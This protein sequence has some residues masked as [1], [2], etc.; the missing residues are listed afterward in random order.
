MPVF[1]GTSASPGYAD[2]RAVI[3]REGDGVL[4][5]P[6]RTLSDKTDEALRLAEARA[7]YRLK[8]DALF[9]KTLASLGEDAAAIFKA[10]R[11]ILDDDT[12]F[13]SAAARS[14]NEKVSIEFSISEEYRGVARLFESI[15]DPL[16]K[17]RLADIGNVC[18]EL[19]KILSGSTDSG[20]YLPEEYG[21]VVLVA[22]D[23]SPTVTMG[24]D[25]SRIAGFVL[26]RGGVTSHTVILAKMLGIPAVIGVAGIRE[27][28]PDGT[29]LLIDAFEGAVVCEPTEEQASEFAKKS[30]AESERSERYRASAVLPAVTLDGYTVAVDVNTGDMES[31]SAFDP[32]FCDGIG[33]FRTEFLYMSKD[34]LPTEDEQFEVFSGA[35]RKAAGKE[36]IIR[37]LDIGAD[38]QAKCV[39]IPREDNP[40]LGYRGIR[41]CL[42]RP[43]I[44][45]PQIRAILRASAFGNV[46]MM[47][48]M[49]VTPDEFDRARSMTENA[50]SQ[51]RDE[52]LPFMED[53][54]VGLMIETPAAVAVC[55]E[56]AE[57]A[58]FFSIG[59]NDL[60][61][62]V[63]A[64]DRTNERV[65]ELYDPFNVS[66]LRFVRTVSEAA[67][68]SGIP[69]GICGEAASEPLLVPLWIAMGVSELSVAP[70]LVG[71]IKYRV[72]K[73]DRHALAGRLDALLSVRRGMKL[74][75]ELERLD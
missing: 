45:M 31:L 75:H 37:T 33:L 32:A 41:I 17:A 40:F 27:S 56:L 16:L 49:I 62:Y 15:D 69:W 21:R 18:S 61:Q 65:A 5:V 51:L 68:S 55:R 10:Y 19:I 30:C 28:V 8:L 70:S 3:I 25:K 47:F 46:K 52:G 57:N 39:N 48:P 71:M 43:D 38:K 13:E 6:R 67:A 34:T 42:D 20:A 50:K 23:L 73:T 4:C 26:E 64:A 35:A 53:M 58:D 29:R 1:K 54:P 7:K 2:A 60:I 24:L 11:A 63:T 9:E 36:V 59:T 74:R 14:A 72:S 66:V 12:F 22:E 44:F